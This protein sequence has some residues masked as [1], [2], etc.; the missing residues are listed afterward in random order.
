MGSHNQCLQL[1][2]AVDHSLANRSTGGHALGGGGRLMSID[3]KYGQ[4]GSDLDNSAGGFVEADG[5]GF[6][7]QN[8]YG[9]PFSLDKSREEEGPDRWFYGG[10]G[11]P[12]FLKNL[13]LAGRE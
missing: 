5:F 3:H 12:Q 1:R 7:I 2:S 6:G 4:G 11:F 8:L 10:Q 13:I 9:V